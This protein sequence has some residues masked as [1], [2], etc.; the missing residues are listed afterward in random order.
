MINGGITYDFGNSLYDAA[1][2]SPYYK[3]ITDD[4]PFCH[5]VWQTRMSDPLS[6]GIYE[7]SGDCAENT[8]RLIEAE[9]ELISNGGRLVEQSLAAIFLVIVVLILRIVISHTEKKARL[10]FLSVAKSHSTL[11]RQLEILSFFFPSFVVQSLLNPIGYQWKTNCKTLPQKEVTLLDNEMDHLQRQPMKVDDNTSTTLDRSNNNDCKS[12]YSQT[13]PFGIANSLASDIS[14]LNLARDAGTTTVVFCD[15]FEFEQF[16]RTMD[17]SQL[18]TMMDGLFN[19]F[20]RVMKKFGLVKVETVFE[21]YLF[22]AG[23]L[24]KNHFDDT[25]VS[26]NVPEGPT[27]ADLDVCLRRYKESRKLVKIIKNDV[28]R[29]L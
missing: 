8:A 2:V 1:D 12:A 25:C 11:Q 21:T 22:A 16:V 9:L 19:R 18:V 20:D 15:I 13:N 23:Y 5:Y 26:R 6:L 28:I 10:I 27:Q 17:P 24:V 4:H 3:P 7:P 14:F 29:N